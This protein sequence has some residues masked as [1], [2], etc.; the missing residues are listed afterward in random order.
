MREN[1]LSEQVF[2]WAGIGAVHVRAT[3]FYENLRALAAWSLA[4]DGTILLP[5]GSEETVL[6]LVSGEDVARVAAALLT[7]PVLAPG[8]SHPVIGDVLRLREIVA[9]FSRVLERD[10]RYQEIP[11]QLWNDRALARGFN[12]HAVDHLSHLWRTLRTNSTHFEVTDTIEKLTGRKPATFEEFVRKE[13]SA[14]SSGA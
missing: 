14:F 3:V 12:Q 13:R 8:S 11:D 5:W 2:E 1:Y 6:P 9:T 10:V 7:R 4:K